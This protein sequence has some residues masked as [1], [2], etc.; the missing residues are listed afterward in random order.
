[1][2]V[3]QS[4]VLLESAGQLDYGSQTRHHDSTVTSIM[5]TMRTTVTLDPDVETLLR[6]QV[7]QSG[8]PFKQVLNNAVRAG[9][10]TKKEGLPAFRPLTFDMGKRANVTESCWGDCLGLREPLVT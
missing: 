4:R 7:R 9:L 1:M 6:K 5:M 3:Q 10:R 2:A 8:Q